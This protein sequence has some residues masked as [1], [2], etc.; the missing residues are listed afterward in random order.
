ME[1]L[2]HVKKKGNK[3]AIVRNEDNVVVGVSD[4]K[5]RA[6][7]S[8]GYRTEAVMKK[9]KQEKKHGIRKIIKIL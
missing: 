9:I 2:F 3:W 1:E 8:A 4:Y 7:R 5:A 6:L